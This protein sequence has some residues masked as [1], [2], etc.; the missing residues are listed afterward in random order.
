MKINKKKRR[1]NKK[2]ISLD[3]SWW[4]TNYLQRRFDKETFIRTD[5]G[6]L[7]RIIMDGN[8]V[9]LIEF[10]NGFIN[11]ILGWYE[12]YLKLDKNQS[13]DN[14]VI[15]NSNKPSIDVFHSMVLLL[16]N[17]PVIFLQLVQ[18]LI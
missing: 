15:H 4:P 2:K 13:M 16:E 3:V 9:F 10:E 6:F 18:F 14:N 5:I 7:W 1:K 17:L 8:L 11:A 12:N